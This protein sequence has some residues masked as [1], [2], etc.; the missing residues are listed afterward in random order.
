MLDVLAQDVMYVPGVGPK[1]KELLSRELNIQTFG[2]LLEYYPYKYVDRSRIYSS[3]ELSADMPFVQL[4]GKILSF[5][6]FEMGP[7][8]KRVVAHFYDG[9]GPVVDLVWFAGTHYVMKSY[10]V[11]TEYIVFGKPTVYGGRFQIAHPEIEK[12]TELQLDEMGMQ[13]YYVTT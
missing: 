1:K 2:D 10:Q 3:Q 12:A 13:P 6:Q 8:K 11:Q 7:R 4:K 9:H 5:E